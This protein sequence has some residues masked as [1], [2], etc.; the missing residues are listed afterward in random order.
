[1][2]HRVVRWGEVLEWGGRGDK[3][4]K[5]ML[6]Q[7]AGA[8]PKDNCA[9]GSWAAGLKPREARS[10]DVELRT[11]QMMVVTA[12]AMVAEAKQWMRALEKR[13]CKRKEGSS[14]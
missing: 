6:S 8:T 11:T 4:M 3:V 12:V 7:D 2:C 5:S 10:G 13:V 14:G 1:M 9:P